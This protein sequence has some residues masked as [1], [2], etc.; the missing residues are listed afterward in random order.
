MFRYLF[1]TVLNQVLCF[2]ETMNPP[3]WINPSY[4]KRNRL[5]YFER[6]YRQHRHRIH[7]SP[8]IRYSHSH[9]CDLYDIEL[10]STTYPHQSC[11]YYIHS[12]H[13]TLKCAKKIIENVHAGYKYSLRLLKPVDLKQEDYDIFRYLEHPIKRNYIVDKYQDICEHLS[14]LFV[15]HHANTIHKMN[16]H[17]IAIINDDFFQQ[18]HI[19]A[20][21]LSKCLQLFMN[22]NYD[23][24]YV[25]PSLDKTNTEN[26]RK[27]SLIPFMYKHSL[28]EKIF[29]LFF[30][31]MKYD[32]HIA[33]L[34]PTS[35][36]IYLQQSPD[37]VVV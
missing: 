31:S 33:N 29:P 17:I 16:A 2:C 14:L 8:T 24:C 10:G 5:E 4:S 36:I 13:Y 22:S 21:G 12:P 32:V 7:I 6:L 15:I 19:D 11:L 20:N 30:D 26:V 27:K 28:L 23:L 25:S 18:Y 9:E 1:T 34:K 3:K 37:Y 35:C